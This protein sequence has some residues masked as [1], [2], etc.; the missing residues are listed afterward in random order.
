MFL[1]FFKEWLAMK[2]LLLMKYCLRYCGRKW[3][4][5]RMPML[6]LV[7]VSFFCYLLCKFC[8]NNV[9]MYVGVQ[10]AIIYLHLL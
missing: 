9:F 4:S 8:F 3:D 2:V 7:N 1:F 5:D 6:P 10:I